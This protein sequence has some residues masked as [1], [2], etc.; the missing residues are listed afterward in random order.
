MPF[1][2]LHEVL[3]DLAEQETRTFTILE[4]GELPAADYTLVELYCDEPGC[5][6]RRV[7]FSVI[8]SETGMDMAHIGY[9]WENL[10]FYKQWLSFEDPQMVKEMKGPALN[11]LSPQS[12]IAPEILNIVET[13]VLQDERYIERLKTH[14]KLFRSRI[15]GSHQA[16][17][18]LQRPKKRRNKRS[19]QR[20]SARRK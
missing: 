4:D 5:D 7:I 18:R 17:S 8:S 20:K 6:C 15:G 16:V 10:S 19:G 3:P 14:Y 13:V 12:D 9:G 2:P 1:A 11:P